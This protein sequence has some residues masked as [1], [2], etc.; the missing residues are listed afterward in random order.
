MS[1]ADRS[2]NGGADLRST[3]Y[4]RRH[5]LKLVGG[6]AATIVGGAYLLG[7]NL[8]VASASYPSRAFGG[9]R[10]KYLHLVASDGFVSMPTSANPLDAVWPESL[11]PAGRNLYTFGFV[12]P[13]VA[14]AVWPKAGNPNF[15]PAGRFWLENSDLPAGGGTKSFIPLTEAGAVPGLLDLSGGA[16][17]SAPMLYF[18]EGDDVVITLWNISESQRPEA[19]DFHTI[20]FHGFPNQIPYFDGVPDSSLTPTINSSL[21]YRYIIRQPGSFMYHCHVD[22]VEHVHMG[23]TGIVFIRPAQNRTGAGGGPPAR[24]AGG[25]P[26]APAGYVFNDGVAPGQPGSTSYDREFAFILTEA[27]VRFH[28]NNAHQQENDFSEYNPTFALMN[29][30]AY[31]DTLAPNRP[32]YLPSGPGFSL[33]DFEASYARLHRNPWSS[34][35]EAQPGETILLRF[36]N[37]GFKEH[38]MT[39]PGLEMWVV[40]RD[41]EQLTAGRPGFAGGPPRA[42]AT[43]KSDVVHLGP[44]ESRD[45]LVK[46]P[47]PLA[48]T[49]FHFYDRMDRFAN[50]ATGQKTPGSIRTEFRVRS[51]LPPQTIPHQSFTA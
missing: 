5:F 19:P 44:G 41:S 23:L 49:T 51:G 9:G 2:D 45:V 21:T 25:P 50:E 28:W 7:D 10:Q 47:S 29:G 26:T 48:D 32:D 27:D 16:E 18:D 6:T 13:N 33:A 4:G 1:S 31:P 34:L 37:L 15:A 20:H 36:S 46:V 22:D 35:I 8:R 38:S 14:G 12:N 30:R 43:W 42:D 39:L 11:A 24:Y 40:G 17:L 3:R